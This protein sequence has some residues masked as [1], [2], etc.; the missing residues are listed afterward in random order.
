MVPSGTQLYMLQDMTNMSVAEIA[1]KSHL[2][3]STVYRAFSNKTTDSTK[4][5]IYLALSR[6][7]IC[8]FN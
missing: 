5:L 4:I 2:S 1:R 7:D 6:P 8:V 3:R